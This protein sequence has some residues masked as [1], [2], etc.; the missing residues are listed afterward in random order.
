MRIRAAHIRLEAAEVDS[1][2][3]QQ[4]GSIGV[5]NKPL[6]RKRLLIV[7]DESMVF[8][9]VELMLAAAG[10]ECVVGASTISEATALVAAQP[11]DAAM[12]DLNIGGTSSYP[13]A[14]ALIARGVPFFFATGYHDSGIAEAYRAKPCLG[15]PFRRGELVEMF[16]SLVST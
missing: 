8:H 4:P 16:A 15:K 11:F 2:S 10:C 3:I 1:V 7:D 9:I 13:V 12:L 5:M 14:D 6:L